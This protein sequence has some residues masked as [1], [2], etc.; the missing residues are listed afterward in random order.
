MVANRHENPRIGMPLVGST[1]EVWMAP[2]DTPAPSGIQAAAWIRL[3]QAAPD[4][5]AG[6][7]G[8]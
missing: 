3:V 8:G 5:H 2:A 7:P 4:S 1:S 6:T